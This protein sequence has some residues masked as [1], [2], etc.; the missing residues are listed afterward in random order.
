M[1]IAPGLI[2]VMM[3]DMSGILVSDPTDLA[4]PT[5]TY[6]NVTVLPPATLAAGL[7][8]NAFDP[9]DFRSFT[10]DQAALVE[11]RPGGNATNAHAGY[12]INGFD[13]RVETLIDSPP[14]ASFN[15]YSIQAAA[16]AFVGDIDMGSVQYNKATLNLPQ[17]QILEI[18]HQADR[19]FG[20]LQLTMK[21]GN[22]AAGD[23]AYDIVFD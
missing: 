20:M 3:F 11:E 22:T 1:A 10:F 4:V 7:T 2:T 17:L 14:L 8:L 15:P 13:T 18:A 16:T 5:F 6:P 21:A 12:E 19:S 9:D 23:D